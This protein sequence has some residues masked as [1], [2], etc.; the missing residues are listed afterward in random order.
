MAMKKTTAAKKPTPKMA[1]KAKGSSSTSVTKSRGSNT[2]KQVGDMNARE[3]YNAYRDALKNGK[4]P[5]GRYAKAPKAATKVTKAEALKWGGDTGHARDM[6]RAGGSKNTTIK[7]ARS[8]ASL[9]AT[10]S[11][12]SKTAKQIGDMNE[13]ENYN[14]VRARDTK[15]LKQTNAYVG[16][17]G[18]TYSGTIKTTV[19]SNSK[20]SKRLRAGGKGK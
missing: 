10:K 13:R 20:G 7:E 1:A 19:G 8:V 4:N 16:K 6:Q 15:S 12:G 14:S 3:L 17:D 18:K 5:V 11:R 2:G 9:P